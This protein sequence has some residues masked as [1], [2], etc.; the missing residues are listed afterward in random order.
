ME[1]NEAAEDHNS[2][3]FCGGNLADSD[4]RLDAEINAHGPGGAYGYAAPT[5]CSRE[6]LIAY[7]ADGRLPAMPTAPKPLTRGERLANLG[8]AALAIAVLVVVLI[9][10]VSG[11]GEVIHWL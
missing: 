2:C 10:F 9:G 1:S 3:A 6:H 8:C 11:V 4:V 7:F 5:F